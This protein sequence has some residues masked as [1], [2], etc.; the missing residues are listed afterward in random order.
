[1]IQLLDPEAAR[2]DDRERAATLEAATDRP[3]MADA[4][5][6]ARVSRQG[7]PVGAAR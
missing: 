3:T 1:M 4:F 2:E 5:E 7:V 6:R